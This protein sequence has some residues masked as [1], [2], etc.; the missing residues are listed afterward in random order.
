MHSVR[1]HGPLEKPPRIRRAKCCSEIVCFAVRDCLHSPYCATYSPPFFSLGQ[2]RHMKSAALFLLFVLSFA[3][4]ACGPTLRPP[5]IPPQLLEQEAA[6]QRELLF[7]TLVDRR[8]RLQRIYTPLRIA[9]ADL[10]GSDISH[11][12]H[13]NYWNRSTIARARSKNRSTTSLRN[14]RRG[15]DH[16]HS[17][18]FA[19]S[20][21]RPSTGRRD[22]RRCQRR[23]SYAERMEL[24]RAH[25][26]RP[27]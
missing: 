22:D 14:Q 7:K 3:L 24:E 8:T 21:S 16:R 1:K 19:S 13:R 6:L 20:A 15:H 18:G 2:N 12:G 27:G 5:A 23:R 4:A 9:N 25:N 11:T 26:S 10:C 17:S